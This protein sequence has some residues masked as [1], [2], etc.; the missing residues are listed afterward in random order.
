M[1]MIRNTKLLIVGLLTAFTLT[2]CGTWFHPY[3]E[4]YMCPDGDPGKCAS[5]KSAYKESFRPASEDFSPMVKEKSKRSAAE[6]GKNTGAGQGDA[7]QEAEYNYKREL[8]EELAG[9]IQDPSTP[10]LVPSKQIRV[11]IP[12]YVADEN[13]YYGH[14]YVYFEATNPQWVLPTLKDRWMP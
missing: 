3:H 4:D 7:A 2:G 8:Y 12:G 10:V 9:L 11:L 1:S 13:L 6:G 5:V 14:R